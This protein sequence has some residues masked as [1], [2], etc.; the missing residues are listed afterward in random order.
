VSKGKSEILVFTF[1]KKPVAPLNNPE[2]G[3]F[4]SFGSFDVALG[5]PTP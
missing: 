5:L 2:Y 1:A 4:V 3:G